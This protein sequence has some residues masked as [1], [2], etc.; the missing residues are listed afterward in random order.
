MITE[1]VDESLMGTALTVQTAGG[2]TI[3]LITV[4]SIPILEKSVG[5][6][7]SFVILVLGPIVGIISMILLRKHPDSLMIANGKK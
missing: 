2:F 7:N 6:G 1:L 5:W 4:Y 3:A